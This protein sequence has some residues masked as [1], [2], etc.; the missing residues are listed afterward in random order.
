VELAHELDHPAAEPP[1]VSPSNS[2]SAD[3]SWH[4]FDD[5]EPDPRAPIPLPTWR[6][7]L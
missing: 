6:R 4:L 7:H 2:A 1:A 3:R 5:L